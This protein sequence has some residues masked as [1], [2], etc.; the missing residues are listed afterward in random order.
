M[1]PYVSDLYYCHEHMLTRG[2]YS[3]L[4][5]YGVFAW[6]DISVALATM[7]LKPEDVEKS[8]N[9]PFNKV[10]AGLHT[11]ELKTL[12]DWEVKFIEKRK[13]PVVGEIIG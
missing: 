5:P 7:S 8:H 3:V 12:K 9:T 10:K 13:Y 11:N 2:Y 6:R 1:S 4:G